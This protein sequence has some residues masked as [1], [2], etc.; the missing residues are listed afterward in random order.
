[1]TRSLDQKRFSEKW[2]SA[3]FAMTTEPSY[4]LVKLQRDNKRQYTWLLEAKRALKEKTQWRS[5]LRLDHLEKVINEALPPNVPHLIIQQSIRHQICT[6]VV[7]DI[8]EY[9]GSKK[10]RENQEESQKSVLYKAQTWWNRTKS[11]CL[12]EK[13]FAPICFYLLHKFIT[14]RFSSISHK[15]RLLIFIDIFQ[16]FLTEKVKFPKTMLK[17]VIPEQSYLKGNV[18]KDACSALVEIFGGDDIHWMCHIPTVAIRV[19]DGKRIHQ[20]IKSKKRSHSLYQ[21]FC[22]CLEKIKSKVMNTDENDEQLKH[23]LNEWNEHICSI[24]PKRY[25]VVFLE[26]MC[27]QKEQDTNENDTSTVTTHEDIEPRCPPQTQ[28]YS[29][30]DDVAM[31]GLFRCESIESIQ[32]PEPCQC[33]CNDCVKASYCNDEQRRYGLFQSMGGFGCNLNRIHRRNTVET[34]EIINTAARAQ[35]ILGHLHYLWGTAGTNR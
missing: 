26:V 21:S 19:V 2:V 33:K 34:S 11:S 22:E 16:K 23:A 6:D 32:I 27:E 14:S 9:D 18:F 3:G 15:Q 4:A 25:N 20:Y 5:Q 13:L 12:G 28:C 17:P 30:S 35:R 10:L 8:E 1:M 29:Y 7:S 31:N 24:R